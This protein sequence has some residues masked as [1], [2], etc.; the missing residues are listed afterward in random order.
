LNQ[1]APFLPLLGLVA[2]AV[3]AH[4]RRK[5]KKER[6]EGRSNDRT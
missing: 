3:T 2:L 4:R 6:Y 1:L 5:A